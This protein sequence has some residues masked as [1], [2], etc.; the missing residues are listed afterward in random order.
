MTASDDQFMRDFGEMLSDIRSLKDTV[1]NSEG[2]LVKDVRDLRD[3]RNKGAGWLS[4][5]MFVAGL[6]GAAI[7][8][9]VNHFASRGN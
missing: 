8:E 9:A 5:A 3:F 6:V 4:G 2:G 1:G 7:T